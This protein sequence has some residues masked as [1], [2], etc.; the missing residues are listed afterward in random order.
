MQP[1][2]HY[3]A[4]IGVTDRVR[5][6][7]WVTG[8]CS[9]LALT[10]LPFNIADA[11]DPEQQRAG[12]VIRPNLRGP[13]WFDM[14][15]P[16]GNDLGASRIPAPVSTAPPASKETSP[17]KAVPG[18]SAG[19]RPI[20]TT[21]TVPKRPATE[22]PPAPPKAAAAAAAEKAKPPEW[23]IDEI[24]A[25][26]AACTK[27]LAG[28]GAVVVPEDPIR[29]GLAGGC[30]SPAPVRLM[31]VGKAPQVTLSPPALVSCD[32][33][34]GLARWVETDL[35]P[36][37][38]KMLKSPIVQIEVMSDYSCRGA[39]GRRSSRL[40]EHARVNA[41][42]IG[43]FRLAD[44]TAVSVL[45]HWGPTG[46]DIMAAKI[47]A[48]KEAREKAKT[49][50]RAKP[51]SPAAAA[52]APTTATVPALPAGQSGSAAERRQLLGL[53][54]A[55]RL[56]GPKAKDPARHADR[57]SLAVSDSQRSR[58]LRIAHERGCKLFG[59]I[60]GPEANEAHRNHFHVD[61]A[62]RARSNFC[63]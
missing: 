49:A 57:Q 3:P 34:A 10:T 5:R 7:G 24:K 43:I 47:A 54:P 20:T 14:G 31:S 21:G 45:T 55:S 32:M 42:D 9:L 8:L 17:R 44:R 22:W 53:T 41:L 2:L 62:P 1:R 36:L 61:M 15:K 33:A 63:E 59:T 48:E 40:S 37:A 28:L 35:Q 56:G 51:S 23:S 50:S 16:L 19:Q 18:H 46:R 13:A 27:L 12:D 58:F 38:R 25:A 4:R 30:G 39:Y 6:T 60:L 26:K 29:E 52:A 11:A